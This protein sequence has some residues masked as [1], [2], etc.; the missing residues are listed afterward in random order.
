MGGPPARRVHRVQDYVFAVIAARAD[1]TTR[2][3]CG[4]GFMVPGAVFVTC[5][6]CV[7]D[8]LAPHERYVAG[9]RLP[10]GS[11]QALELARLARDENGADLALARMP[12]VYRPEPDLLSF[13]DWFGAADVM[14][15]TEVGTYGSTLPERGPDG[16]GFVTHSRTLRG[17]IT[18]HFL[19]DRPGWGPTPSY[20]LDMPAPAGVSGAP[21]LLSNPTIVIGVVYG[22][23]GAYSIEEEASIDPVTK[24]ARPEVRKIVTFGLALDFAVLQAARGPATDGEPLGDNVVRHMRRASSWHRA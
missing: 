1:A 3:V 14:D 21:L 7:S 4:T 13:P 20:E 22:S 6:H 23:H 11:Y 19:Y 12:D 15:G 16:K 8:A 24:E 10:D 9:R 18:R 2:A 17:Y 5:W